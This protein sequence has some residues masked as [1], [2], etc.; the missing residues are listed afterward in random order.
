MALTAERAA[1]RGKTKLLV[2][3][4]LIAIGFVG[5]LTLAFDFASWRTDG[6]ITNIVLCLALM[7]CGASLF[8]ADRAGY[9]LGWMSLL[10]TMLIAGAFVALA[11]EV[12]NHIL[13]SPT[14]PLRGPFLVIAIAYFGAL[15]LHLGHRRHLARAGR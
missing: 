1:E 5:A 7:G 10:G 8:V 14:E 3:L 11:A 9:H 13:T 12:E 15:F 6:Y 2:G 4:L